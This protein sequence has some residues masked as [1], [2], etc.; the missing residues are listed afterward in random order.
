M[1]LL[2]GQ[3]ASGLCFPLSRA[4]MAAFLIVCETDEPQ[5]I[6]PQTTT[7]YVRPPR[8][9]LAFGGVSKSVRV[10]GFVVS[11]PPRG[12]GK[13][14]GPRQPIFVV[15]YVVY[16]RCSRRGLDNVEVSL[17]WPKSKLHKSIPRPEFWVAVQVMIR[18]YRAY[19]YMHI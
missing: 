12:R 16:T 8:N 18:I 14:V 6:R 17:P 7:F 10:L 3:C 19:K 1:A 9:R 5:Q 13:N 15:A 11:R 2:H 4:L